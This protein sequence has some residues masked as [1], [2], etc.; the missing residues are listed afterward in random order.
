MEACGLMCKPGAQRAIK[1]HRGMSG[2]AEV[3]HLVT[4]LRFQTDVNVLLHVQQILKKSSPHCLTYWRV[5]RTHT[6]VNIQHVNGILKDI[7]CVCVR[8][9][10]T[11]GQCGGTV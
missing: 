3:Q 4:G 2:F 8:G 5:P 6:Y 11:C 10:H 7:L 1:G 9:F